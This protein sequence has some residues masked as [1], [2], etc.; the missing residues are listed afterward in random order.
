MKKIVSL[1]LALIMIF[2][3]C[4]CGSSPKASYPASYDT[5]AA[6][7]VS[8]NS[9]SQ[10]AVAEDYEAEYGYTE[11]AEMPVPAPAAGNNSVGGLSAD[12]SSSAATGVGSDATI[13]TEKIIYSADAQLETT[14]FDETV[15]AITEMINAYGGFVESSSV[16]GANYY[17]KS[18]GYT[19][20]RSA[21]YTIRIPSESF[22]SMM[23]ALPTLG[24]VPFTNTY[25]E[26]VTSQY[27]DVQARLTAYKTQEA[28]LIEMMSVA[29]SVEDI[30]TIEDRLT[31]IRY[32]IDSM[33]SRLNNWDRRVN[34]STIYL[35][36]SEVS[37]YTPAE[38]VK[39]TYGEKLAAAVKNGFRSVGSFFADFLL[40]L[41]EALPTL[42]IL[43][44]IAVVIIIIIRK[45][46]GS[47]QA[48]REKRAL[49]KAEKA[50]EKAAKKA[51][52]KAPAVSQV[53][54]QSKTQ[55]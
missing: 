48:R 32:Q 42:I 3:L 35:N 47:R 4:A 18:R 44:V 29:E 15:A 6:S 21:S 30:I 52:L 28:R 36:V 20:L 33:Q 26:N 43:A 25:T 50:E 40:W 11:A 24:N 7:G 5:A 53:T 22:A 41:V 45:T 13:N 8:Y 27:Y 37:E 19:S 17:N 31:E 51:A 38:T 12:S 49:R 16:N 46:R 9:S 2:A 1:L 39:V 14:T 10:Y 34:Y 54:E 23:N 55:E